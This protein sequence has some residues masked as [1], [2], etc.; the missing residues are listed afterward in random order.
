VSPKARRRKQSGRRHRG[1][2]LALRV[3]FEIEGTEK[4]SSETLAYSADDTGATG[5]VVTFA[6]ALVDGCTEHI[7]VV[8]S[9]I[10]N[11]SANWK[12]PDLGKVERAI[13][14]MATYELLFMPTTPISVVIDESVELAKTYGG[15]EAGSFVNGVLGNI[16]VERV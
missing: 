13:L 3:L 7:E 11:A 10:S 2:E 9:A 12:L 8:D 16:A 1:R 15:Q 14:R 5:D 4:S 6:S